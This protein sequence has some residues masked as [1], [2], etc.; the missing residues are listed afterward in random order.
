MIPKPDKHHSSWANF[1]PISLINIDM[2]ILMKILANRLNC[3]L[4]CL[5]KK[6]QVGFVPRR[7][8]GDAIRRL[9]QI[10]HIAHNRS[11]ETMFLSL[12]FDTLSWPY[13]KQ[14]L[15]HYGFGT[16]FLSWVSAIY[17]S[18]H[19][20]IKYYG[21]E[22]PLFPIKRGTLQGCQLSPLLFILAL[23]LLAEVV[24]THPDITGVE[25]ASTT[26]KI[27]LFADDILLSITKPRIALPNLLSLLNTFAMFSGLSVNLAKSKAMSINLPPS[28][29]ASLQMAFSFQWLTSLPYLRIRLTP[30]YTGLYH[31]DSPQM[32]GKLAA[33]LPSWSHLPLS[34][35]GRIETV[36]MTY[37]PKLLYI[38][39]VLPV[40]VPS[41]I[42][43]IHQRKILQ[44]VWGS[45]R[46]QINKWVLYAHKINGGLSGS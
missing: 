3:F 33:M 6:D 12:A 4:P 25:V 45:T 14:V 31:A 26:H 1:R 19:A 41:H 36:S 37:F 21:F 27:S 28:Q 42:L 15:H 40:Q 7:Q 13:L 32:F 8:A 9:L 29:L 17:D 35:F 18:P 30:S 10:Q 2:K 11:L 5:I 39:R 34:W 16:S 44:F 38:F 23:E 43:G 20:K 46:P 22:S 24:R